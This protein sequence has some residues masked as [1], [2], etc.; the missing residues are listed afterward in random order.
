[1]YDDPEVRSLNQL[2]LVACCPGSRCNSNC[3]LNT[4]CLVK[5][6]ISSADK[7]S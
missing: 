6:E 4:L 7:L 2:F 1:M 5:T 3:Q